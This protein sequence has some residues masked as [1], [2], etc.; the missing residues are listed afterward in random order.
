MQL[1]KRILLTQETI[2]SESNAVLRKEPIGLNIPQID[3]GPIVAQVTKRLWIDP[4]RFLEVTSAWEL[5]DWA[6][7][8]SGRFRPQ[9][10]APTRRGPKIVYQ[11]PSIV[12][13]ALIQVAWQMSD[14]AVV[15]YFR[16]HPQTAELAGFPRGR[17]MSVGQDWERRRALGIFPFWWLF[18]A[19]VGQLVRLGV[20]RGR[21]VIMDGTT[22]KAW[23]HRDPEADWRFPKP[24]KGSVWGY[25]ET[26]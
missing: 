12:G 13:L 5:A 2:M 14:E 23:F 8:P 7:E 18:I 20:I 16:A 1:V 11:D 10:P 4:G 6:I 3:V 26:V 15:D 22:L 21:D 24:W 19:F 9:L 25:K 17:V